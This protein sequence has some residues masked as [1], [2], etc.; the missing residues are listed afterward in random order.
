MTDKQ[1]S[2]C[3]RNPGFSWPLYIFW[4]CLR[5]YVGVFSPAMIHPDEFFQSY[6]VMAQHTLQKTNPKLAPYLFIPWEYQ[7]QSPNRSILFP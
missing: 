3:K 1:Q 4:V 2:S 6:E 5:F 7:P